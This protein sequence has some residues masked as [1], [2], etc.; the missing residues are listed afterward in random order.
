LY[1]VS[2]VQEIF[3]AYVLSEDKLILI[4]NREHR[5]YQ[6]PISADLFIQTAYQIPISAD[7]FIQ[8]PYQIPISADLFIQTPE[9]KTYQIVQ[10]NP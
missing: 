1:A 5:P 10:F 7:L 8:T 4:E 6:I 2:I 9:L 3:A